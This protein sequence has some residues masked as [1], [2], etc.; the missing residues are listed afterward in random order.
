M[1]RIFVFQGFGQDKN[2][3]TRELLLPIIDFAGES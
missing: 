1:I 2:E 3:E